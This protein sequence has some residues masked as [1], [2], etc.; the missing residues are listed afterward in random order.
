[1]NARIIR[2]KKEA[3][4]LFWPWCA[5]VIA[6]ALPAILSN[7][8]TKKLCLISFFIGVPMLAA[9]ALGY[10]FH[11]RTFSLW[12][13]QPFSRKQ[14]WGEKI[15][16]ML[17]AALSAA[18]VSGTGVFYFIW[19][20]LDFTWR[21][22]FIVC[23]LVATASAPFGT[24]AGRSTL[25]G[26]ILICFYVFSIS[27]LVGKMVVLEDKEPPA[28]LPPAAI[29]AISVFGFCYAVLVLWLGARKLARFQVTGGSDDSDLL[30]AGPSVMPEVLARWLRFRPSG[31]FANL[32]RK[33]LRLLRPFWLSTLVALLYLALAA[34]FRRL[35]SFPIHPEHPRL[36]VGF[37]VFATLGSLFLLAPV[38]AGILSLGE[39]RA[40][41]TQA[42]HMTLPVSPLRQWLIKLA[43][44]L[45]AGFSSAV[46]LP[47]LVVIAVGSVF[48]SP[49]LFV[50]FR[51]LRDWMILVPVMTFASFWCACAANGTVRASLWVATVPAAILFA[52]SGGTWLGQELARSTGTVRDLVLSWFHLS[53][54]AFLSLT[55]SARAGV[56]W[57]FVPT[58]LLGLIQSYRLF[59]IQP[60]DSLLWMLRCL[61]P[62][63]IVTV[64]WSFSVSAGFV[65]S[66]WEPFSET[67]QALDQL[68]PG[69]AKLQ[70]TGEDLSKNPALTALT[71]RWLR[72]S[73]I[74]V[75]PDPGHSSAYL[76]TFHLTSGLEC[77]LTVA[78]YGGTAAS[79]AYKGP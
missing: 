1:M 22:G 60:Q 55:D 16:V 2:M 46:L 5:V 65:S 3:R 18:L 59:R 68:H 73:N 33:E 26:F 71:R 9:L 15:S 78:H 11:Q 30:M 58:L 39:E 42:W 12:L 62:G 25:G 38:F 36:A 50:D 53:P 43:M 63:A 21:V 27:L 8:Y 74:L 45:L 35:T 34:M 31:A 40:S 14:L 67:R 77:R 70:L 7:S 6:G 10:E 76:A 75:V 69:A 64:L 24:L 49:L 37:A 23:V 29:T 28:G 4:A 54:L 79:C 17:A 41:G 13:T 20:Q 32:I 57:L 48:G 52:R 72:G 44:A 56:L 47:L 66:R 19:P 61:M 51:E